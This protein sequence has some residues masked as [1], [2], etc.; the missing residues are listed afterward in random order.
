MPEGCPTGQ[1]QQGLSNALVTTHLIEFVK[2]LIFA[3]K[4][5][6][7]RVSYEREFPGDSELHHE[8]CAAWS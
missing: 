3:P 6:K 7:F 8:G 2:Y 1:T 5:Q 4:I